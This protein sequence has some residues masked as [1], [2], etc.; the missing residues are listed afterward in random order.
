[1]AG[2]IDNSMIAIIKP[3][4]DVP[5]IWREMVRRTYPDAADLGKQKQPGQVRLRT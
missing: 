1:M 4:D 2:T 3:E 5:E